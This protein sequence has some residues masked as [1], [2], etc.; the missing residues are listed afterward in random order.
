[1]IRSHSSS[2]ISSVG[3]SFQIPALFTRMSI[4]LSYLASARSTIA[5]TLWAEETSR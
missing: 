5:W 1:M 3:K 2:L 4:R